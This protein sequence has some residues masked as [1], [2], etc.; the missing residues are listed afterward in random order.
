MAFESNHCITYT[1]LK[2][3]GSTIQPIF[4]SIPEHEDRYASGMCRGLN[5]WHCY[6]NGLS[7]SSEKL[8][9]SPKVFAHDMM[10]TATDLL[11]QINSILR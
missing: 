3:P 1:T 5:F 7:E 10:Q 2:S 9:R 11:Q 4:D 8:L 6:P